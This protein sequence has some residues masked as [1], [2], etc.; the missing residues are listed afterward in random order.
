MDMNMMFTNQRIYS[1]RSYESN[2]LEIAEY[3]RGRKAR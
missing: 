1:Q 3:Y 2:E